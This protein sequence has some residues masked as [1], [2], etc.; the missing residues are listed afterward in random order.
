MTKTVTSW[1]HDLNSYYTPSRSQFAAA[2]SHR[3]SIETRLD[4]NIGLFRMFE[5]GSLRHGTGVW[6]YSDADYL[7]SLKGTR[8]GSSATMLAKVRNVLQGRFLNTVVTVRSPAVVCKFSDGDVEI[9]PGYIADAAN[10]GYWIADPASPG[11]WMKTYPE[12]HN[13]YVNEI[14]KKMDGGTKKLA[15]LLKIWKY[16]RNVPVSSFYLEMQAARHLDSE[17]SYIPIYDLCLVL[18]KM[19]LSGLA[20]MNDPT[21]HGSRLNA[22]SSDATRKDSLSKLSSATTRAR[23]ALN[24]HKDEEHS[25]AIGQLKLLFAQ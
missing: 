14:N 7:A 4:S 22:Y 23:R 20:A 9:V 21:G 5:I 12:A 3:T 18:N 16:K 13:N 17:S 24:H 2:T 1:F 15:R 19:S 6:L 8:P 25:A 11:G 10:T